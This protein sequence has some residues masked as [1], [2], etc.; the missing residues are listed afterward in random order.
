MTFVPDFSLEGAKAK[1]LRQGDILFYE[2]SIAEE[3]YYVKSGTLTITK[4][5]LDKSIKLGEV[6]AGEFISERAILGEGLPRAATA[7]AY[8]D[9]EVFMIDKKQCKKYGEALPPFVRKMLEKMATRLHQTNEMVVK[10]ARTQGMVKDLVMRMQLLENSVI[11][12]IEHPGP[13]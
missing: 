8:T 11:Q 1:T 12:S 9:C 6:S 4:R 10:M 13:V 5:V 2:G 3:M 7:E